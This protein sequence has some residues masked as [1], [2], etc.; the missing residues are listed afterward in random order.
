[1][2]KNQHIKRILY[3]IQTHHYTLTIYS[4]ILLGC[5]LPG[6]VQAVSVVQQWAE[7]H[8]GYSI[9]E[10]P[11]TSPQEYVAV[12]T[13]YDAVNPAIT[14]WHFIRLD[15]NG[16]IINERKGYSSW[17][18]YYTMRAVDIAVEN[19]NSFWITTQIRCS[20]PGFEQDAIVVQGVDANGTDL[21]GPCAG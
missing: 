13:I 16:N 12:G 21:C 1:T 20:Y 8:K 11:G 19:S 2:M 18:S 7:S 9:E 14:G 10:V 3:A 6:N 4:L 15:L 17:G 5:L